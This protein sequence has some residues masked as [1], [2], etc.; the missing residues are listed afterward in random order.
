MKHLKLLLTTIAGS[1]LLSLSAQAQSG[2]WTNLNSG[3]WSD[4]ANWL[5][6][7]VASGS[8]SV[9]DFSTT[10]I[11]NEL[12]HVVTL[13]ASRT[14]GSLTISD[15]DTNTPASW[16]LNTNNPAGP[17]LTLAGGTTTITVGT[18]GPTNYAQINPVIAGTAGFTKAG[19]GELR[20]T[21]VNTVTGQINVNGGRLHLA[22]GNFAGGTLPLG[23]TNNLSGGATL[24]IA[25][26]INNLRVTANNSGTVEGR[27]T[28]QL[29]NIGGGA[30]S[31]LNILEQASGATVTAGNSWAAGGSI[32]N[33]NVT[34]TGA[35]VSFLRLRPNGSSFDTVNSLTNTVLNLDRINMFAVNNSGGNTYN[36][37]AING[38]TNAIWRGA[39]N[40]AAYYFVGRMN[41]DMLFEGTAAPEAAGFSSFRLIKVGTGTLTFSGTNLT[42]GGDQEAIEA[43]RGGFTTIDDGAI[44][45][46]NGA[47][48]GRGIVGT[49]FVEYFHTII[50][51]SNGTYDVTGTTNN[52]TSPL[53]VLQGTG[54]VKG[55]YVH[56]EAVLSP[57]G[58]LSA[59]TL[60]FLNDLTITNNPSTN[61]LGAPIALVTSNSTL[62][63]D[64]SPSLTSGNDR[65][66]VGGQAFVD[67]NP[68]VEV[69]F[70]GGASA[71]AYTLVYATN[72]V[73]GNPSSWNVKW[74]GR[75]AAP[76]V[77]A[78]A[79]EV[80]LNVSLG[81]AA[82][83]VWSGASNAVWDVNTTSNWNNGGLGDKFF[84]LDAVRFN[85]SLGVLANTAITLNTIVTPSSM[86]VSNDVGINPFYSITGSGQIGGGTS[87]DKRGN[88]TLTLTTVN[89]YAG[90]TTNS[91]GGTLDIGAVGNALGSGSLTMNDATLQT[92]G[93][94]I[95]INNPIAFT[96]NT[97]NKLRAIGTPAL[98]IFGGNITGPSSARLA[99][100][101]DSVSPTQRGVDLSGTNTGF[102]GTVEFVGPVFIRFRDVASAGTSAIR[103][104]LGDVGAA[105]ASLGVNAPRTF[106]LGY[107]S[108]GAN[109]SLSGHASGG[110]GAG[111]DVTWE[112]GALGLDM[113]FAGNIVNGVPG[114]GTNYTAVT[115][116]GAGKLT[117][118]GAN[119]TY[120]GPTTV[121]NGI[122]QVDGVLGNTPVTLVSGTTL[123]GNGSIGGTVSILSG[124]T[125]SPGTS[126]GQM[127]LGGL[128]LA[129]TCLMELDG[130]AATNCDRATISG[131]LNCGGTLNVVNLGGGLLAG[132]TFQL[133]IAANT[134]GS[135][136]T[137]NL[138]V[139]GGGLVWVT[140]RLYSE[141]VIQVGLSGST[142]LIW[143]GDG[144]GNAWSVG[145][146]LNW[147]SNAGYSG[148]SPTAA[149]FA[150]GLAVVI[151]E[152]GSNNVPVALSGTV[153]PVSVAV[154]AAKNYTL[155]G[156]G[157]I[158]GSATLSKSG[159][160]TLT[161]ANTNDYSGATTV[162]NG[163]L[164]V[165]G[166]LPNSAVTVSS[167]GD[168]RLNG[169]LVGSATIGSG[170]T[171][172][173]VGNV[174]SNLTVDV[175]GTVQPGIG[176]I[177]KLTVGGDLA[178][179]GSTV[180]ELNMAAPATNDQI[181]VAGTI[182]A[183]GTLTVTNI[184]AEL[185][186]G[187]V[188]QL[189]S[190]A[191]S[192][193]ATVTLPVSNLTA[194]AA[195]AW[196][197]NIATDGTLTLVSGG[198]VNT[199]PINLTSSYS[200]GTLT[201][202]WPASHLGWRL[203]TQTNVL[204]IGLSTN[205]VTVDGTTN[206]NQFQT[207][208]D[209]E[210]PTV[211]F[212]LVYP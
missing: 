78:T 83:L 115:K 97:T 6:G 87:L 24:S 11:T 93:N 203:M 25:N 75:G 51:N 19:T 91:G 208:V 122:L 212:Q 144:S 101:T 175:G 32:S 125:Y 74:G 94:N 13:D 127:T 4:T 200:S 198:A 5:N 141:G 148:G 82:T 186:N 43:R 152:T 162:N 188:F 176:G 7:I 79:N 92:S 153:Q 192:G 99:F 52:T 171:L 155:G 159:G 150:N 96:A 116:V 42:Y 205:W 14:L 12:G 55:A 31:T 187:T 21:G 180:L 27:V 163:L 161:V 124:A 41:K 146:P 206:V 103:W 81:A 121:S 114:G 63:L 1:T 130:A 28:I 50:V 95:T 139:L 8:G 182:T 34:S 23:I 158:S 20:L 154:G 112:I 89:T 132:D 90:G 62:R 67:G 147:L 47:S 201:I 190:G 168:L 133:F 197:D 131:T 202:D 17:N 169:G 179:A 157:K 156:S 134:T 199:T 145:G 64:I 49:D 174:S 76:T 189:F 65:I 68:D 37:G 85:E 73:V 108:G 173:G 140:N 45:L 80:K 196:T 60:T 210:Q 59:G 160:G 172:D 57:A 106:Q 191:A 69:N 195:Y 105:L 16:I 102:T 39:Q 100:D 207:L 84:Q 44:A 104:E 143:K 33:I 129:G 113:V 15:T 137:I 117:L 40:G 170:T 30:N 167:L 36:I 9:A 58:A 29:N 72:G 56:D 35:N 110:G 61:D 98:S 54:K 193:F 194:T 183:G 149:A 71:G 77:T 111:S 46:T 118:S 109:S 70:L 88:G 22:G 107:L 18:L 38:T 185:V 151:D 48:F 26:T 181:Q 119:S 123:Q 177:G 166:Q 142:P 211:F 138:P 126:I 178:L 204:G 3:L 136:G 128:S 209:P 86:V 120:T 2:T 10:D 53:T 66:N 135:F 184:G 165:N 164:L